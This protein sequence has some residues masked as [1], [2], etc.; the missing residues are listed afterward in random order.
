MS[1]FSDRKADNEIAQVETGEMIA[2]E[3]EDLEGAVEG[4]P[5][6][7][8]ISSKIK[9]QMIKRGWAKKDI[10]DLIKEPN[11]KIQ[12]RDTRWLICLLTSQI[13]F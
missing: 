2:K 1:S 9:K 5:Q 8:K 11:K 3:A 12:T 6:E 10:E 7:I 4:K 13:W